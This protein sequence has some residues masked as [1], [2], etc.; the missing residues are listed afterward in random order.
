MSASDAVQV[1]LPGQVVDLQQP[2]LVSNQCDRH[3]KRDQA[4]AVVPESEILFHRPRRGPRPTNLPSNE[5]KARLS[6][7]ELM[8]GTFIFNLGGEKMNSQLITPWGL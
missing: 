2:N 4:A 3:D 7:F 5:S 8:S 6:M 1:G